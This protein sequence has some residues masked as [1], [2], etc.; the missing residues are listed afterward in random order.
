MCS[1]RSCG[2]MRITHSWSKPALYVESLSRAEELDECIR[3][4]DEYEGLLTGA[5]R[6]RAG[7]FAA[8]AEYKQGNLR[9]AVMR[10]GRLEVRTGSRRIGTAHARPLTAAVGRSGGGA[11][12]VPECKG[13]SRGAHGVEAGIGLVQVLIDLDR[14][15]EAASE[16][17][18]L[19]TNGL[20]DEASAR[21]DLERGRLAVLKGEA[22]Q[23]VRVLTRLDGRAPRSC[24][25]TPAIGSPGASDSGDHDEAAKTLARAAG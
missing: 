16:L 1:I 19:P 21:I 9:E 4:Y 20:G 24:G 23:A 22:S 18:A 3:A 13:Q 14:L 17:D 10:F 25:M 5:M 12:G 8:T 6:E 11:F 2:G 7:Y 15:D